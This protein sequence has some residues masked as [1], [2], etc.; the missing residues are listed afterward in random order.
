MRASRAGH[1]GAL[2][3]GDGVPGLHAARLTQ[4]VIESS[5]IPHAPSGTSRHLWTIRG[6]EGWNASLL[7]RPYPA[8]APRIAYE[9][10]PKRRLQA[11]DTVV[12]IS[13]SL[14]S[15]DNQMPRMGGLEA[16]RLIE[17]GALIPGSCWSEG[18]SPVSC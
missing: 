2:L 11:L 5:Q 7:I 10:L 1:D 9:S 3:S 12:N 18:G 4:N 8:S 13:R 16:T 14:M 15:M 17:A 6:H